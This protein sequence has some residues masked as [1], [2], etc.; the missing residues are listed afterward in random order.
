MYIDLYVGK[1][2]VRIFL[3]NYHCLDLVTPS[4]IFLVQRKVNP[5]VVYWSYD[6]KK[7]DNI[8]LVN[9]EIV[10]FNYRKLFV[11]CILGLHNFSRFLMI[12]LLLEPFFLTIMITCGQSDI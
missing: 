7:Y 2:V 10:R 8:F 5:F 3:Y 9:A 12:S 4:I 6:G 11:S 1:I